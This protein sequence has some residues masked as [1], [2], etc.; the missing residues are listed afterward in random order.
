MPGASPAAT[1]RPT[2]T[3]S[4]VPDG[5]LVPGIVVALASLAWYAQEIRRYG[6]ILWA[7]LDLNVYQGGG[8]AFRHGQPV[9]D[10]AWTKID[11]PYTYPPV[12]LLPNAL[13]SLLNH[14]HG[15][16]LM[17]LVTL[18]CIAA[19]AWYAMGM[20]GVSGGRGRLGLAVAIGGLSVWL[21]PVLLTMNLGQVN[22]IVLLLVIADLAQPDHRRVKG[23]GVGL[24]AGIKL[25]PGLFIVYLLLTRR[26]RAGLVASGVFL[27]TV[28]LGFVVAPGDSLDYWG[29]KFYDD[30]RVA[31]VVGPAY[32]GNQSL[33]G[34]AARLTHGDGTAL[35]LPLA[36]VVLVAGVLLG[37]LVQRRGQE[38]A[39][40]LV[41]ALTS[42]LIT[43]IAWTH[44]WVWVVPLLVFAWA[45]SARLAGRRQVL[46]Q[47]G[48]GAL[49]AVFVA[50]PFWDH[51]SPLVPL[52]L[53][54]HAEGA[55]G[56][57]VIGGVLHE[58]DTIAALAFMAGVAGWLWLTRRPRPSTP[59]TGAPAQVTVPAP[60]SGYT[61]ER[62]PPS[63]TV[64]RQIDRSAPN[65]QAA[66]ES[67]LA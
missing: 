26:I 15:L 32:L 23:L 65:E 7:G 20:A 40:I 47:I 64:P 57:G 35:W 16:E 31:S 41:V 43:P 51:G 24:A 50:W 48:A 8:A 14:R 21:E 28:A 29:G 22:A 36:A 13:L 11:L 25:V 39:A 10:L 34:L 59:P 33:H 42:L 61:D 30:K 5:W 55:A 60:R 62:V 49:T 27:G 44:H 58:L 19:A 12:T 56:T 37:V 9:Y 18:A 6:Y 1:T 45:G 66:A 52:G 46:A 53:V 38:F 3:P 54:W 2:A 63:V 4:R 67:T 17:S